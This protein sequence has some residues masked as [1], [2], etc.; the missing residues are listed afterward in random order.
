MVG[1]RLAARACYDPLGGA[2]A[3]RALARRSAAARRAAAGRDGDDD[4]AMETMKALDTA[5]E[6]YLSTHPGFRIP[7]RRARVP[8]CRR[9][10]RERRRGCEARTETSETP[11]AAAVAEAAEKLSHARVPCVPVLFGVVRH[12]CWVVVRVRLLFGC[13]S[14]CCVRLL[15]SCRV[16]RRWR[17]R[18]SLASA[19]SGSGRGFLRTRTRENKA[20]VFAPSDAWR[21]RFA[22]AAARARADGP[23]GAV[24]ASARAELARDG[25]HPD[26][27]RCPDR[28]AGS[29]RGGGIPSWILPRPTKKMRERRAGAGRSGENVSNASISR[30]VERTRASRERGEGGQG[31]GEGVRGRFDRL[32]DDD[33]AI[34]VGCSARRR[35]R[36]R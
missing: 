29:I 12:Y 4:A 2:R 27:G 19:V 18:W 32:G 10:G 20:Q 15:W 36:F 26:P 28:W 30:G 17:C 8:G 25:R 31:G 22:A 13:C 6:S 7:S 3:L 11:C 5:L 21:R 35:G 1:A 9:E 33:A 24:A 16:G 14:G 34:V 23:R